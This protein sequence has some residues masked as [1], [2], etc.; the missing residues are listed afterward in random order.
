MDAVIPPGGQGAK[1]AEGILKGL[2]LGSLRG[3]KKVVE[4]EWRGDGMVEVRNN[5]GR[6]EHP[7]YDMM[8]QARKRFDLLVA[9]QSRTL[10]DTVMEYKN[11]Y[12]MLPPKGFDA[13][14]KFVIDKDIKIVDDYDR[15]FQDIL[16]FHALSPATLRQRAHVLPATDF[17]YTLHIS[18]DTVSITGDRATASRPK[19]MLGMIEGF[20]HFL[21][22][23]FSLDITGSDH[24]LGSWV[25]GQ[26]QR[27][28]AVE[29]VK[30]GRYFDPEELKALEDHKRNPFVGWFEACAPDSPANIK[31][32]AENA[33]DE[34]QP[35]TFIHQH[36]ATYNFCDNPQLK[37]LHGAL[38]LDYPGR[39]PSQLRPLMVLSKFA[40]NNELLTVP[41]Q[42]YKNLSDVSLTESPPW[43]EKTENK[44]FWRGSTT[45]G[46]NHQRPW[47]ES[48]RTR[49]HF[50]ING[51]KGKEYELQDKMEE[52]MMPDGKGGFVIRK[53]DKA[54]LRD[55]YMNV[56]LT[57]PPGQCKST[58]LCEALE[59]KI[60]FMDRVD[61]RKGAQYK[62]A[63]DVDGNGWSSRFYRL[64]T[65][66]SVVLKMTIF[67]EW[68]TDWLTPWLHYIPIKVDYS[69]L[70]DTMAFFAGPIGPD[71]KVDSALGHEALAK[72]IA[73]AGQE[74]AKE[75]WR[76][77]V[78]QAYMFRLLLEYSRV[79][80]D[81]RQA[82]SYNPGR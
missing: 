37:R 25:L 44:L 15:I 7:I 70:Y 6:A 67:P 73:E 46:F 24:D 53:Y 17:T 12:G 26:D 18:S 60:E 2:G 13:W 38:S 36:S 72:Q 9:R 59:E 76:W 82:E 22:E 61:P 45:G 56:G 49:L 52:V 64:L 16:P 80:A 28:R 1:G 51:E 47:E 4:H 8:E 68:N 20:R 48:H 30:Q 35:K 43:D 34:R 3:T 78:M 77:E 33:T 66:G 39:T 29:L 75:H 41:L 10:P 11:R 21:P 31:P 71:G 14:W 58:N 32:W 5:D 50:D 55:A 81:D 65:S 19:S 40:N 27:D 62:Y 63:L 42:A 23:D 74:F 69:D 54:V 79:L 57:G